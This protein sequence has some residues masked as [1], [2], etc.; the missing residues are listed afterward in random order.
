MDD[1]GRTTCR[2]KEEKIE[3]KQRHECRI[4]RASKDV[5]GVPPETVVE[6][7]GEVEGRSTDAIAVYD[8]GES[9]PVFVHSESG[10]DH[11]V[12]ENEDGSKQPSRTNFQ[13]LH[14]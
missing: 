2:T 6:F 5:I 11:F 3:G 13:W 12:V 14:I 9:K 4:N 7:I 8:S 10:Q 1:L